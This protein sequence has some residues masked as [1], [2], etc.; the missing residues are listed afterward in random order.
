MI[1]AITHVLLYT[2]FY[3]PNENHLKLW[4]EVINRKKATEISNM[5][6][7]VL[8]AKPTKSFV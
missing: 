1:K 8:Y 4:I 3:T 2:H 6:R 7:R 5:H